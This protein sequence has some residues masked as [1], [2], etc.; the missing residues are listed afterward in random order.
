[1]RP[2][3]KPRCVREACVKTPTSTRGGKTWQQSAESAAMSTL[4]PRWAMGDP[5]KVCERLEEMRH[6]PTRKERQLRNLE[7]LFGDRMT[8]DES[9]QIE[10]R[11]MTWYHWA[12]RYRPA[13]G[14]PRVSPY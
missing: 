4:L 9:A 13:L 8:S 10:Q 11:L 1:A 6:R 2:N 3:T 12:K 14:A 5:S 7:R